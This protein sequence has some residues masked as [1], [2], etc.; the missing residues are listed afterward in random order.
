M[1]ICYLLSCFSLVLVIESCSAI[2]S[3]VG[4]AGRKECNAVVDLSSDA[5]CC[6]VDWSGKRRRLLAGW[7][8][9]KVKREGKGG[10]RRSMAYALLAGWWVTAKREGK[11]R[12][13]RGAI[14]RERTAGAD[15]S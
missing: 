4:A 11:D 8:W 15:R 14:A 2:S 1:G 3:V 6:V 12:E 9:M 5:H 7:S 13:G 10:A